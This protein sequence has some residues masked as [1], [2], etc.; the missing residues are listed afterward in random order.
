MTEARHNPDATPAT[1]STAADY[2][3]GRDAAVHTLANG[4][5]IVHYRDDAT[6]M[7]CVNV[8]YNVGG[9]NETPDRT[10]IAHLF[11]HLMFGPSVH[12][13]D[14]DGE[15]TA[16]GGRSN[17]WTSNDFTNFYAF[18]PAQNVETLFHLESD[19][20]LSLAYD[21]ESL[22]VQRS[23]V[24]EEF[25]QQCLNRPYGITGHALSEM[26]YPST[27]TYSWPVI[28]K[29]PDHIA[30]VTEKDV[31]EWFEN[32]YS[33]DNAVVAVTGNIERQRAFELADKWFGD[34][35]R[36]RTLA[37]PP[38]SVQPLATSPVVRRYDPSVPTTI[39]TMAWHTDPYGTTAYT[40]ADAITDALAAGAASRFYRR[41]VVGGDGT[42]SNA[43]ASITGNDGPGLLLVS[44]QLAA[45]G[46]ADD[47]TCRR[48]A[49]KLLHECLLLADS[50]PVTE[51]ELVRM[52]NRQRAS[53]RL[54]NLDYVSRAASL[55]LAV[56]RGET[57]DAQLQ[58]YCAL[59]TED[60][61][62]TATSIFAD[63]RHGTIIVGPPQA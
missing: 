38:M 14:Y 29:T 43:E 6:A 42:F 62:R 55:A 1:D 30:A 5:R 18:A 45:E 52:Q 44:G 36:R 31:R 40:A 33:P 16:A 3:L 58:R 7:V 4:L 23:V 26:M 56:L 20:M 47:D 57:Q 25:K 61:R 34:I 2:A 51:D 39:V 49:D 21:S 22:R 59:T 50:D 60:I 53:Y 9:R 27:H 48:A 37:L 63:S 15:L 13:P 10:G 24:I 32:H 17:A 54:E 28:G 41:V 35:P 19:R 46:Y 11:E 12:I 8:L